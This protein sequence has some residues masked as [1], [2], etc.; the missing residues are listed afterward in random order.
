MDRLPARDTVRAMN[1]FEH[2]PPLARLALAVGGAGLAALAN[3]LPLPWQ[4]SALAI[5]MCLCCYG[6]AASMG[7]L[8]GRRRPEWFDSARREEFD[9]QQAALAEKFRRLNESA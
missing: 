8:L 1:W 4:L 6:V 3:R 7:P 2:T 9:R 5:S